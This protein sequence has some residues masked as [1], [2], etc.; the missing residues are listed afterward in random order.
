VTETPQAPYVTKVP[1]ELRRREITVSAVARPTPSVVRLRFTGD[2]L[3]DLA[4]V[5]PMDHV[6][7]V[8]D[9][10]ARPGDA[11]PPRR[12]Y[13]LRAVDPQAGWIEVDVVQHGDP[14]QGVAGAWAARAQVGDRLAMLGPKSSKV[15]RQDLDWY[16]LAVDDTGLPMAARWLAQA[17]QGARVT[18]LAEIQSPEHAPELPTRAEVTAHWLLRGE[19]A[20]GTTTL[21]ADALTEALEDGTRPA[22]R[23]FVVVAGE[24]TSLRGIKPYL[25]ETVGMPPGSFT[26]TGYWRKG[27]PDHDHHAEI[28]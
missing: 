17:P 20:P 15:V 27:V 2:D 16:L 25:R 18:L 1:H 19:A 7:L 6:K 28:D 10:A 24:A 13:T 11:H 4:S 14:V 23:G 21:L 3:R 5:G 12:D 22:D 26:L 9:D 8:F